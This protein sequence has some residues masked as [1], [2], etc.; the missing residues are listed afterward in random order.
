MI[1]SVIKFAQS[2]RELLDSLKHAKGMK[3]M[4]ENGTALVAKVKTL[5]EDNQRDIQDKIL[6]LK[7]ER[8]AALSKVRI[9]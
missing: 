4:R 2:L 7:E 3:R 6:M 8:D 5:R 1:C 9:N